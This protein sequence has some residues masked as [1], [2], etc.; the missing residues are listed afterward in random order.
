MIVVI[1]GYFFV[2]YA[3]ANLLLYPAD[4][5]VLL[6]KIRILDEISAANILS[7]VSLSIA[8]SWESRNKK[9]HDICKICI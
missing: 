9:L 4:D 7:L 3:N 5:A 1:L 6:G 2:K 8:D